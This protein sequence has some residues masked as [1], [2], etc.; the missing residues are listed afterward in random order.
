MGD[1]DY[2]YPSVSFSEPVAVALAYVEVVDTSDNSV[3]DTID[4]SYGGQPG[5]SYNH[6]DLINTLS[7]YLEYKSGK[8]YKVKLKKMS[9]TDAAGN[10]LEADYIWSFSMK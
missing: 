3:I 2:L 8:T 6:T 7:F 5:S 10:S 9:V 1:T 4:F